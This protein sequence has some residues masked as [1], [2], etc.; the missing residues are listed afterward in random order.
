MGFLVG[1]LRG[2]SRISNE[3][4]RIYVCDLKAIMETCLKQTEEKANDFQEGE[5]KAIMETCLTQTEEK[6]DDFQEGE[7]RA[8]KVPPNPTKI[9]PNPTKVPPN[10]TKN[11]TKI[12][13]ILVGLCKTVSVGQ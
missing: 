10:P 9:S 12:H 6:A 5:T 11:P 1:S 7:T 8:H 3:E 4:K 13:Q 2:N